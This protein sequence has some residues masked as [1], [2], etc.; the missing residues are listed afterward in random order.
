MLSA[1]HSRQLLLSAD[2]AVAVGFGSTASDQQKL[3][4]EE[5]GG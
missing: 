2:I 4:A 1:C 3:K 5:G